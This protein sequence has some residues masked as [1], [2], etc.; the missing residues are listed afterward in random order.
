MKQ[1]QTKIIEQAGIELTMLPDY[2]FIATHCTCYAY[3]DQTKMRNG[4]YLEIGRLYFNPLKLE[5]YK[6]DAK[7]SQAH[8]RMKQDFERLS[9]VDSVQISATGQTAKVTH[10]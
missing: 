1:D 6:R 9:K 8:E 2:L 10:L 5:I 4:D 3:C 7:Y